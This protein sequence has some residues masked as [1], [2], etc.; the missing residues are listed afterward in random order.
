M[1]NNEGLFADGGVQDR[2]LQW[3]H[4]DTGIDRDAFGGTGDMGLG[5]RRVRIDTDVAAV[6]DRPLAGGGSVRRDAQ[7]GNDA[8]LDGD[9]PVGVVD[10]RMQ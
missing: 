10:P 4:G 6:T 9:G 3:Q 1:R 2:M 8:G 7:A 5:D